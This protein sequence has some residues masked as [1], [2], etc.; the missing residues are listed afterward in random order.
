MFKEYDRVRIADSRLEQAFR[1]GGV[2]WRNH[3]Q[4][5]DLAIPC[6][7][8]LTVLCAHARCGAIGA[9]EYDGTAHL[10]T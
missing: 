10:A 8:V 3:F 2:I 7:I 9:T 4:P 5:R 6:R 1:V